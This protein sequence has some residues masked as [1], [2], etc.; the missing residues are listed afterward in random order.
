MI[1]QLPLFDYRQTKKL[2]VI[3][4]AKKRGYAIHRFAREQG[5]IEYEPRECR[6]RILAALPDI[7]WLDYGRV[8]DAV[9]MPHGAVSHML[10]LLVGWE[11]IEETELYFVPPG[12]DRH[13]CPPPDKYRGFMNGY[14]K[15]PS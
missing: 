9:K 14:R 11:R 2:N 12:G 7:D 1:S 8:V 4:A 15:K 6:R 13:V 5:M 10:E 3:T